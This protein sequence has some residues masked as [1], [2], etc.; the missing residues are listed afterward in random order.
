VRCHRRVTNLPRRGGPG[1][2]RSPTRQLKNFPRYGKIQE[3]KEDNLFHLLAF[4]CVPTE[5]REKSNPSIWELGVPAAENRPSSDHMMARPA[6]SDTT[7]N[8]LKGR[9]TLFRFAAGATTFYLDACRAAGEARL[10]SE[11]APELVR[12]ELIHRVFN[13]LDHDKSG[14]LDEKKLAHVAQT[15]K[16]DVTKEHA[17]VAL[18]T[19]NAVNNQV[20]CENFSNWY[21]GE[22]DGESSWLKALR[23]M[24]LRF[25]VK[26][27]YDKMDTD[28][29]GTVDIQKLAYVAKSFGCEVTQECGREALR[30]LNVELSGNSNPN[31]PFDKFFAWFTKGSPARDGLWLSAIRT[32][33]KKALPH[34]I[35]PPQVPSSLDTSLNEVFQQAVDLE[36]QSSTAIERVA[37]VFKARVDHFLHRIVTELIDQ[38]GTTPSGPGKFYVQDGLFAFRWTFKNSPWVRTMGQLE[39][40]G[41][42][43]VLRCNIR[44]LHVPLTTHGSYLGHH[45]TVMALVPL[46][47]TSHTPAAPPPLENVANGISSL[48][49]L[50][51]T[52]PAGWQVSQGTDGRL[53]SLGNYAWC[54]Y[55][56]PLLSKHSNPNAVMAKFRPELLLRNL[57]P[58][59]IGHETMCSGDGCDD[60]SR[61]LFR[62]LVDLVVPIAAQEVMKAPDPKAV[63]WNLKSLGVPSRFYGYAIIRT[64]LAIRAKKI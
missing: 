7:T 24:M 59:D 22:K 31:V 18:A 36:P 25:F 56:P 39:R 47:P 40:Q 16:C 23:T 3:T 54:V 9:E 14:F 55:T 46:C 8:S 63:K 64:L 53:Y 43:N 42:R 29:S 19:L 37:Q 12:P 48:L 33:M 57:Q 49:G 51:S 61:Q 15:C 35:E 62:E 21:V 32:M 30:G 45:F 34:R 38:E 52:N 58:I 44:H 6:S 13:K 11:K 41:A 10:R 1:G 26:D 2:V 4:P 17:R 20:T 60:A 5:K 27:L 28:R 50:K